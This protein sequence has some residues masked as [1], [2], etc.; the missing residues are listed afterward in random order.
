[1]PDLRSSKFQGQSNFVNPGLYLFN[2]GIDFDLTPK[3][4]LINNCNFLWFNKTQTLEQFVFQEHIRHYIG[5]DLSAGLE[6]RPLLSNNLIFIGG[7]GGL[8]PGQGFKDLYN[9]LRG[10]SIG[11]LAM[12]FM[13]VAVVF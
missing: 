6:Y 12:G 7:I 1:V 5:V 9:P 13:D 10:G 11:P 2:L 3:L 4:K 8:I